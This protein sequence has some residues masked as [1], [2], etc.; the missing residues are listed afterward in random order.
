MGRLKISDPA[1]WRELGFDPR[2][3][4]AV[5]PKQL[6]EFKAK[7]RRRFRELARELHPDLHNNDPAKA[8]QLVALSNANDEIQAL[9]IV[10]RPQVQPTPARRHG[11]VVIIR[12]AGTTTTSTSTTDFADAFSFGWRWR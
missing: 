9:K 2:M 7:S 10:K 4:I 3:L 11:T 6:E 8:E 12:S 1:A 5:E